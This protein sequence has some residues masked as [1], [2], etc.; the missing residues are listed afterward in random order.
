MSNIADFAAKYADRDL[1]GMSALDEDVKAAFLEDAKA[2]LGTVMSSLMPTGSKGRRGHRTRSFLSCLGNVSFDFQYVPNGR[3]VTNT[4]KALG[5]SGM[6]TASAKRHITRA[7]ALA[8]SFAEARETLSDLAS[9]E[10]STTR[11]RTITLEVGNKTLEAQE[12]GTLRD[13]GGVATPPTRKRKRAKHGSLVTTGT[14]VGET[15]VISVDGTGA[16]CTH[17]DTDGV[18]GKD[19]KEA[20]TRELK[21]ALVTVYTHVDEKGHPLTNRS[22][23]SYMVTY[24]SASDLIP[25]L[26]QEALRRGYGRIKRVQFIG[27]GAEWIKNLW[28]QVFKDAT[29][30]LDFYHACEYLSVICKGI[31]AEG[32]VTAGFKKLKGK[33]MRYGGATLM[34]FLAKEY[35]AEIASLD[36]NGKTAVNY[37]ETRLESMNYGWLRREHYYIGSGSVESAC[38]FLVAARCKQAGM[39][40]RHKNAAYIAS[41]RAV[42]RSNREMAA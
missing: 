25:G 2:Y 28:R 14:F 38:K 30:T 35:A 29:L 34:R 12:N 40:W 22:C 39:H 18:K 37:L 21:V 41:I 23:T 17:A 9:T 8:G 6:V 36:E 4:V 26:R 15:M 3:Q 16:P 32:A 42:I 27:D 10:V 11:V 24:K 19:D 31:F 20:G 13:L 33:L 7:G 1:T 5:W